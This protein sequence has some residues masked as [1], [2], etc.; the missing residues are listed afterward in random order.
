MVGRNDIVKL[1]HIPGE[2]LFNKS[3]SEML[4]ENQLE[5]LI[6][7]TANI[8]DPF[9]IN[10]IEPQHIIHLILKKEMYL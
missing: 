1:D 4:K 6:L 9:H 3:I 5:H 7:K 10:D 2:I 8:D